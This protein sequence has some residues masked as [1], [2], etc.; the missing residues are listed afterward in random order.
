M[1]FEQ[2]TGRRLIRAADTDTDFVDS[3]I[4]AF[5]LK[6]PIRK[7]AG[8][9]VVITDEM[10]S[11]LAKS[12]IKEANLSTASKAVV[13]DTLGLSAEQVTALKLAI[14]DGVTV[15]KPIYYLE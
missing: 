14:Q 8:G 13:V 9:P 6:G 2:A 1:R 4:G 10:V 12:T 11:G 3:L 15:T 7:T 5:D